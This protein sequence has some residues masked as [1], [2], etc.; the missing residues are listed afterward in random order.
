MYPPSFQPTVSVLATSGKCLDISVCMPC[1]PMPPPPPLLYPHTCYHSPVPV[2]TL[3]R[4]TNA[5]GS[6]ACVTFV[7][8]Q[9]TEGTSFA[10]T[11]KP[12]G[13]GQYSGLLASV[14]GLSP[15]TAV[16]LTRAEHACTL[17]L[18]CWYN[19]TVVCMYLHTT[20]VTVTHTPHVSTTLALRTCSTRGTGSYLQVSSTARAR[21]HPSLWRALWCRLTLP[22]AHTPC[23]TYVVMVLCCVVLMLAFVLDGCLDGGLVWS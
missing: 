7:L 6:Y 8:M 2:C 16:C 18:S 21:S 14:L 17:L 11:T 12:L 3:N 5:D 15:P 22:S 9:H 1:Q 23:P 10:D 19:S 4:C 13:L 20:P